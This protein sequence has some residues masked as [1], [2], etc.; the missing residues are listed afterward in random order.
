MIVS[1]D[2]AG[3]NVT[4]VMMVRGTYQDRHEV[5]FVP[6]SEIA[7]TIS[8]CGAGVDQDLVGVPVVAVCR[9]GGFADEVVIPA[10]RVVAMPATVDPVAAAAFPI[11]FGTAHRAL[12]DR[13]GLRNGESLLVLGAS[14]AVGNAAVQLGVSI[15]ATVFVAGVRPERLDPVVHGAVTVLPADDP[16]E[17]AAVARRHTDGRGVDVVVDPVGG[18]WGTQAQ[19]ALADGGRA[20][21]VG[22]ATGEFP[23]IAANRLLLRNLTVHGVFG[24]PFLAPSDP[25]EAAAATTL[26]DGLADGRFLPPVIRQLPLEEAATALAEVEARVHAGRTVL[27]TGEAP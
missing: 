21:V 25:A 11:A 9:I 1:V 13:T 5:P 22:F 24:S 4:D 12:V 2:A 17:L 16:S 26:L 15:G 19:R 3:V 20:A 10:D 27:V 7:G 23:A 18:A 14:G 8:R 6:G